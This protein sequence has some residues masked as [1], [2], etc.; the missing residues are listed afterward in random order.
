MIGIAVPVYLR[1][2]I[3]GHGA[4]TIAQAIILWLLEVPIV[5]SCARLAWR[6]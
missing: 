1:F 2:D 3:Q 4:L 6:Y 5:T